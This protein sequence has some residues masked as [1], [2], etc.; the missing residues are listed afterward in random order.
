MQAS[1]I[2]PKFNIPWANNAGSG[3]IRPIP[4]ASQINIQLG[5]ASLYDGFPPATFVPVANGGSW[6]FG[7]DFNGILNQM[8]AWDR[9]FSAGGP[10]TYDATFMTAIGGYPSHA[11]VRDVSGEPLWMSLA[12]NNTTAPGFTAATWHKFPISDAKLL[13]FGCF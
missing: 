3:M 8:T 5:A 7:Q 4:Q 12:D 10:I 9:W 13:Y 11:I 6:P 1:G 2:P